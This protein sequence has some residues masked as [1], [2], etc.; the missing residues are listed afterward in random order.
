MIT[1]STICP[2]IKLCSTVTLP[3]VTS[4][5]TSPTTWLSS[6]VAVFNI[7]PGNGLTC[8][9]IRSDRIMECDAPV[10]TV[11]IRSLPSI[12]PPIVML[13]G[14]LPICDTEI[15]GHSNAGASLRPFG[16]AR[17]SLTIAKL[18]VHLP[19]PFRCTSGLLELVLHSRA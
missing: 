7:A 8:L 14:F 10:S 2:T 1:S 16:L 9:A 15:M 5:V 13:L 17:F 6:P 19:L 12:Y 11:N 4:H 3:T 18:M